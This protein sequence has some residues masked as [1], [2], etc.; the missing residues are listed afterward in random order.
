[1]YQLLLNSKLTI[2][3]EIQ[4]IKHCVG[5]QTTPSFIMFHRPKKTL[6]M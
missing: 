1:M 4:I 3:V 5:L 2:I 6:V